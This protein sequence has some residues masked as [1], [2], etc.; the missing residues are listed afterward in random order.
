MI[1]EPVHQ[2]A[3]SLWKGWHSDAHLA[4]HSSVQR[5]GINRFI[6]IASSDGWALW[7]PEQI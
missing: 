1:V 7:K 2:R 4:C 3:G 6:W 5:H